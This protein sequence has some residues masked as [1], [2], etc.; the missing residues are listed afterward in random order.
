V[1]NTRILLALA[2]LAACAG[3]GEM[4]LSP[5]AI[6]DPARVLNGEVDIDDVSALPPDASVTVRVVDMNS[7]QQGAGAG[8]PLDSAAPPVGRLPPT[9]L[10][11]QTIANPG[12]VPVNFRVE[13]RAED[14]VLIRGLNIEVRVSYGGKVQYYNRNRYAVSLGNATDSHRITVERS[15]P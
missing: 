14:D 3:C 8:Q 7:P 6:G 12:S 1:K 13:Y 15:G 4:V 9:V 2:A 5:S 10:G 11:A